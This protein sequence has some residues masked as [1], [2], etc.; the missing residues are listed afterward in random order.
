MIAIDAQAPVCEVLLRT[1][2]TQPKHFEPQRRGE[3]K[4]EKNW[5]AQMNTDKTTS[6]CIFLSVFIPVHL[7]FI[8]LL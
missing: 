6:Y 3:E 7:W 5:K 2:P 8:P 1:A 4:S